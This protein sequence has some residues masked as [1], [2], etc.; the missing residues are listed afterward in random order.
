MN[1]FEYATIRYVPDIEREE[2]LNVGVIMMC[3][4]ARFLRV[5][6][7]INSDKLRC[8]KAPHTEAELRRQLR[9]FEL[10]GREGNIQGPMC[11]TP[12]EE[13]FRWLTAVKSSCLQTSRPH[14]GHTEDLDKAFAE[15]YDTLL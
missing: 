7:K 15:L 8:F 9:L 14:P 1:L 13:R 2:F 6:L 3:K 12:V 4:R 11:D 5:G 10:V